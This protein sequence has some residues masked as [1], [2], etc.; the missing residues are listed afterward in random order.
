MAEVSG[1]VFTCKSV[2]EIVRFIRAITTRRNQVS[3]GVEKVEG[4]SY[5]RLRREANE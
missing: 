5:D 3:Y 2:G 4:K 1:G